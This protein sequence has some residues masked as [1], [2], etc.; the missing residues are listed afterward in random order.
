MVTKRWAALALLSLALA[1]LGAASMGGELTLSHAL[2]YSEDGGYLNHYTPDIELSLASA[3]HGS[4]RGEIR[5]R[6]PPALGGTTWDAYISR[7][8]LR[9]RL[10]HLRLTMGKSALSWG[11][12]FLFNAADVP[13]RRFDQSGLSPGFDSL[14]LTSLYVPFGGFDFVEVVVLPTLDGSDFGGGARLYLGRGALKTEAGYVY[15]ERLHC[16]YVSLQGHLG[17][18]WWLSSSLDISDSIDEMRISGGI[19]HSMHLMGG[20]T[21]SMRVEALGTPIGPKQGFDLGLE[22]TYAPEQSHHYTLGATYASS[23]ELLSIGVGVSATPLEAL[24]LGIAV[25]VGFEA[26]RFGTVGATL[27]ASWIF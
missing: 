11:D 22:M 25:N 21:L 26:W 6:V 19:V 5:V 4:V 1:R 14:W 20:R 27:S 18:D 15:K 24:T 8:Y 17:L 7:A 12:G 2:T 23:T 13:S 3:T 16:P 10:P 9:A